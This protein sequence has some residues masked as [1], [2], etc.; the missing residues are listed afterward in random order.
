MSSPGYAAATIAAIAQAA[1]VSVEMIYKAFGGKPGLV[2]AIWERGLPGAGPAPAY[3]RS[4]ALRLSASDPREVV[5]QW[6]TFTT[7]V[8]PRVAPILLLIR[9]AAE[10]DPEMAALRAEVLH[11]QLV[12]MEHNARHLFERGA[13]RQDVSL[14]QARDVLLVY[15]SPE[16]YELLVLRQAWPLERYGRFVAEGISAALL[17]PPLGG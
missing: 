12:R 16:L 11:E 1:D 2:R 4:D 17:P 9:T 14:E 7:E 15:S 13:L 8:S 6:G 3:R 5:A 10:I